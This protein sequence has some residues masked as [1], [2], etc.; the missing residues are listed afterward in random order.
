MDFLRILVK[1]PRKEVYLHSYR[2][3]FL[4]IS[5]NPCQFQLKEKHF[6]HNHS[7]QVESHN[8]NHVLCSDA[9][10]CCGPLVRMS[11][12]GWEQTPMMN[13]A[14]NNKVT[15]GVVCIYNSRRFYSENFWISPTENKKWGYFLIWLFKKTLSLSKLEIKIFVFFPICQ[16]SLSWKK[17]NEF[18][19][20]V[21]S[22]EVKYIPPINFIFLTRRRIALQL[23]CLVFLS[24]KICSLH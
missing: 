4:V 1:T 17:W 6:A 10:W 5:K 8:H 13:I 11:V 21:M 15:A 16:W 2:F 14:D 19:C 18:M 22:Q 9:C 12:T 23:A 7:W 24:R 20:L 3:Y